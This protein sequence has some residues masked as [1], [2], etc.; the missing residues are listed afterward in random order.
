MKKYKT[1][2]FVAGLLIFAG[3]M[4]WVFGIIIPDAQHKKDLQAQL[5]QVNGQLAGTRLSLEQTKN[6][7][8]KRKA[9]LQELI[10]LY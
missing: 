9:L 10:K 6:L 7:L 8:A 2:I 5:D 1:H 4:Y 3:L